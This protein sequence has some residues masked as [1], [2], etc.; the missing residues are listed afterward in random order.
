MPTDPTDIL[1]DGAETYDE[2]NADYGDSWRLVGEI[3]HKLAGGRPI[4]LETK[5]DYISLGLFSRRFDKIARA[6]QGEFIAD[7]MNFEATADAH[8]DE[9]VYAAM[10]AANQ[11]DRGGPGEQA[12]LVPFFTESDNPIETSLDEVAQEIEGL[13]E[14]I[15]EEFGVDPDTDEATLGIDHPTSVPGDRP[16]RAQDASN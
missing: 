6:F 14:E 15:A 8:E 9:M 11:H 7:E 10:H 5:E 1:F 16:T 2:K 12:P 4:T 3:L 13:A